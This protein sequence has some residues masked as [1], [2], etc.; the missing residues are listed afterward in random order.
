MT[1]RVEGRTI[2]LEGR[3]PA[4]D[5]EDLLGALGDHPQ[6][7]VDI[8]GV[9]KLHMAVLQVLLALRPP[10]TGRPP[11]GPLSQDIFRSLISGSDSD[12]E[13]F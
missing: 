12:A 8:G 11:V 4:G 13:C 10:V 3:C 6:G 9:V 2:V 5:A 1:V 7:R